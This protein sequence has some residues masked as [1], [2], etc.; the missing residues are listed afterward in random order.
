VVLAAIVIVASTAWWLWRPSRTD[1]GTRVGMDAEML[2]VL[3]FVNLSDDP[4]LDSFALALAEGVITSFSNIWPVVARSTSSA[5]SGT[6][7]CD[8]AWHMSVRYVLEGSVRTEA[9]QIRVHARVLAC[10]EEDEVWTWSEDR[11]AD[12]ALEM[13]EELVRRI[14]MSALDGLWRKTSNSDRLDE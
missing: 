3:P 2:A 4:S 7:V 1:D 11:P 9:E 10:P 14:R 13:Q 5:Y 8:A 6:P 12:V